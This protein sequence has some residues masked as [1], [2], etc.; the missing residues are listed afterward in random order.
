MRDGRFFL[1][2]LWRR[3]CGLEEEPYERPRVP[4]LEYLKK[5]R[6]S[7]RFENLMRNRLI[8][9]TFRYVPNEIK[10][11]SGKQNKLEAMRKKLTAYEET[12]N[13]EYL[14]DLANYC[15]LEFEKPTLP[16]AYFESVDD[17]QRTHAH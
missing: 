1:N 11:T 15:M 9:G 2:N 4:D 3:S 16:N 12:G 5:T 8:M 14:V 7:P 13:L 17:C 10:F 6:W